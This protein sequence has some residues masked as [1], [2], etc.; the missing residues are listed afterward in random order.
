MF[1]PP[2]ALRAQ[3]TVQLV[4]PA[5]PFDRASF[6]RGLEVLS[7]RYRPRFDDGIFSRSRYLAGDDDRRLAELTSAWRN[8]EVRALFA[9]RGGY[10]VMRLL[11]RL[12]VEALP[13]K[14][15][16]GFSDLTAL[17]LA[18]QAKGRISIH[19]PV[20]TQLGR[21]SPEVVQRLFDLLERDVVAPPLT[22]TETF[23]GGRAEGPLIGGNLSVLTRLIGTPYLPDL[24]GAI[25]LL[26]DVTERPYRL[27]RMWTHL[28][29]AGVFEKVRGIA[30][31]EFTH[32]EE[33]G[34][35]WGPL[36]VLRDLAREVNL[37]CA[38][39]F[40]IGHGEVNC[41]VPLGVRVRLDADARTLE[42][43][44]PAVRR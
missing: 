31:G 29:L 34:E 2:S 6:D 33:K 23:V 13:H 44:E 39:G 15:I 35:A 4:A 22:A 32:C 7:S 19:A 40:P 12:D 26:E 24:T 20:V 37:P 42:F 16:V 8:D 17:H 11:A 10:G 41:A 1:A 38:S 43:L 27:D 36:D 14:P 30:L 3:D 28:R 9:A 5:G 21:S 25:L 18:L